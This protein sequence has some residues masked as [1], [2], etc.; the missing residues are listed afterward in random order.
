MNGQIYKTEHYWVRV[1]RSHGGHS[2]RAFTND[3]DAYR[4]IEK[5]DWKPTRGEAQAD[6]DALAAEQGWGK[7]TEEEFEKRR[8]G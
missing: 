7:V 1:Q 3:R 2:F 6:L 4:L 5:L 8:R